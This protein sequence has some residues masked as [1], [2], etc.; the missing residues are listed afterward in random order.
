V[1]T[2]CCHSLLCSA[3]VRLSRRAAVTLPCGPLVEQLT[4]VDLFEVKS[5][6]R[7]QGCLVVC[8]S[9]AA[10]LW[11]QAGRCSAM[12]DRFTGGGVIPPRTCDIAP[13]TLHMKARPGLSTVM[14]DCLWLRVGE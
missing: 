2:P 10:I 14:T 1:C 3:L 12:L 8:T 5:L 7:A 9:S 13:W 6:I 4:E 11:A